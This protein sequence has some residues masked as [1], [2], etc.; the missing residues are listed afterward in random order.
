M[1]QS[2]KKCLYLGGL[3]VLI[4]ITVFVIK[5]LNSGKEHSLSPLTEKDL[6]PMPKVNALNE[7]EM[8]NAVN[9]KEQITAFDGEKKKACELDIPLFNEL[10]ENDITTTAN[11]MKWDLDLIN[12]ME[13]MRKPDREIT[14][15][16][17]L[18]PDV[19]A[20]T[21]TDKLFLHFIRCPLKT[22]LGLY[23]KDE[24]GLQRL[25][26]SSST[27]HEFYIRK[28][29]AEGVLQMYREYDLSPESMSDEYII[30]RYS[31]DKR[32]HEEYMQELTPEKITDT[33]IAN[34][35]LDLMSA[36]RIMLTPQF[37]PKTKGYEKEFLRIMV[38]RYIKIA[39]L[40]KIYDEDKFGAALSY[41]P[42]FCLNL[43]ENLD[44]ELYTKLKGIKPTS[45]EFIEE[46]N[47]YLNNDF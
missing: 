20:K 33:K 11:K 38:D 21:S 2:K 8:S 7:A 41:A 15:K 5:E 29:L 1:I 19:L 35:C 27:L 31:V 14:K 24:I 39:E 32:F 28:D 43:A 45:M 25:L 3:L 12:H 26:N 30:A 40:G 23:S 44:E 10:V 4:I 18:S 34:I 42:K 16:W 17:D 9:Q 36:D 46:I 6:S 13:N 22:F 47:D 37:F